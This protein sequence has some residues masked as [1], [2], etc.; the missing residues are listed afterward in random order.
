[1]QTNNEAVPGIRISGISRRFG[2]KQVL[3][4][5]NMDI[6][7][8]TIV[9][10]TG[11]NGSGKSTLLSILAGVQKPTSG[12]CSF[13]GRDMSADRS[14]FSSMIGYVPQEDPL[15]EEL[16]AAENLM[17]WYGTGAVRKQDAVQ[18]LQLE[19]F[20]RERV[21]RLSGGMKRRLSIACALAGNPPILLMDEPSASLDLHQKELVR[22]FMMQHAAKGGI[23]L[24]STHDKDDIMCCTELYYLQE[25][26]AVRK[27]AEETVRCLMEGRI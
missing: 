3:R 16:T 4:D 6:Y 25:G 7:P 17:L 19:S 20:L 23:I 26:I 5:I 18:S 24:L 22:M 12:T 11:M 1:M 13:Y 8:G 10:I 2:R 21:S 15:I 9:G 27:N 14:V